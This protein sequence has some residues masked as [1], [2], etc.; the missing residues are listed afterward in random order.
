MGLIP[1][2]TLSN[3]GTLTGTSSVKNRFPSGYTVLPGFRAKE[4]GDDAGLLHYM[5]GFYNSEPH[6]STQITR[7]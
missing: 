1:N 7:Y 3:K 6:S 2:L 4:G 5:R